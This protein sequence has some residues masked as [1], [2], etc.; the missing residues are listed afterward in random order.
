MRLICRRA[1]NFSSFRLRSSFQSIEITGWP[2]KKPA[3]QAFYKNIKL[4]ELSL[5]V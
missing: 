1:P 2:Q 4:T 3:K 5:L